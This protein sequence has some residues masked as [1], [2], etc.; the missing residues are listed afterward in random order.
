METFSFLSVLKDD[1]RQSVCFFKTEKR[2]TKREPNCEKKRRREEEEK[3]REL[4]KVE[5]RRKIERNKALETK[6]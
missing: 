6:R 5:W 1:H 4:R 2:E 3:E